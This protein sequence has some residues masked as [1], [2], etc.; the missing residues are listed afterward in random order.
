MA[1]D[2]AGEGVKFIAPDRVFTRRRRWGERAA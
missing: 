2:Q 1:G